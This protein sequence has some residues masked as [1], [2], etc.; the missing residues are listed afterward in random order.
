M[1]FPLIAAG[2]AA[3][4]SWFLSGCATDDPLDSSPNDAMGAADPCEGIDCSEHGACA[5]SGDSFVCV[6][7]RG[8]YAE[9]A[10]CLEDTPDVPVEDDVSDQDL[11]SVDD[12]GVPDEAPD[13]TQD[14]PWYEA[15]PY[16]ADAGVNEQ[17]DVDADAG[18]K[19]L[20]CDDQYCISSSSYQCEYTSAANSSKATRVIA[21]DEDQE[22]QGGKCVTKPELVDPDCGGSMRLVCE[23]TDEHD[24]IEETDH[25]A[26]RNCDDPIYIVPDTCD[27]TKE[28]LR[29]AYPYQCGGDM[30]Y[31]LYG[32]HWDNGM[33][34]LTDWYSWV[35]KVNPPPLA[36]IYKLRLKLDYSIGHSVGGTPTTE[37][38]EGL[39][40][41]LVMSFGDDQR[42]VRTI[43]DAWQRCVLQGMA[44][45]SPEGVT[46]NSIRIQFQN[47]ATNCYTKYTSH[48]SVL[49]IAKAQIWSCKCVER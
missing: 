30:A 20:F 2:V 33:A 35:A 10:K 6:C 18:M 44:V 28:V 23:V 41:K 7:E 37:C 49:A 5:P 46:S 19:T 34:D 45:F 4:A 22:C 40:Q 17:P 15:E 21:C 16:D 1:A 39:K 32:S 38:A 36:D 47:D 31:Y 48:I 12:E 24:I 14:H 13:D 8:Y 25:E 29:D 26:T 9:G 3:A 27:T 42:V 43:D 11:S